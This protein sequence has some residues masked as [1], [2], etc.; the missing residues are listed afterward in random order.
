[1][2]SDYD[3]GMERDG[4]VPSVRVSR[5]TFYLWRARRSGGGEA[6]FM[7]GSHA[8]AFVFASHVR[9]GGSGGRGFA[10]TI[11][12]FGSA[13]TSRAAGA[14]R[15]RRRLAGRLDDWRH[16]ETG[17]LVEASRRRRRP[18]DAPRRVIAAEAANEEWA[19]DFKG[20][21]AR[22]TAADRSADDHRQP[23]TLSVETRIVA[24]RE[25]AQEG[26]G[27]P[28]RPMACRRRS[29]ATRLVIRIERAGGLTR[30]S[31]WWLNQIGAA[32]GSY[33]SV[34]ATCRLQRGKDNSLYP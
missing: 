15:R 28:S 9:S 24:Q 22:R 8:N 7:D 12:A 27:A 1:M 26:F 5:D 18:L 20:G 2:L 3:T 21:S 23:H 25:G 17:G 14:A 16:P 6:W 29:G 13:Q 32:V 31:V 19:A 4:A 30:L 10:A 33:D 11:S 34:C